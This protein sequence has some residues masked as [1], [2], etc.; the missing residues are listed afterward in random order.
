MMCGQIGMSE[1]IHSHLDIA[2]TKQSQP[3]RWRRI[4]DSVDPIGAGLADLT[5]F[6]DEDLSNLAMYDDT[7]LSI[8]IDRLSEHSHVKSC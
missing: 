2:T 5:T 7:A 1:N 6:A 4:G 3:S 8:L